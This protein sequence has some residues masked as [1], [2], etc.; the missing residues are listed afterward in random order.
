M[1]SR[2]FLLLALFLLQACANQLLVDEARWKSALPDAPVAVQE[3]KKAGVVDGGIAFAM[4][5]PQ[6]LEAVDAQAVGADTAHGVRRW[7]VQPFSLAGNI[8]WCLADGVSLLASGQ[9]G[10]NSQKSWGQFSTGLGLHAQAGIW[11][12]QFDGLLGGSMVSGEARWRVKVDDPAERDTAFLTDPDSADITGFRPWIALG[13]HGSTRSMSSDINLWAGVRYAVFPA[14]WQQDSRWDALH[15]EAP[16]VLQMGGGI[17]RRLGL[18]NRVVVGV[19]E[20]AAMFEPFRKVDWST[21]WIVQVERTLR[22]GPLYN[23]ERGDP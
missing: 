2:S 20:S 13:A 18:R 9:Y 14:F 15:I 7:D 16:H 6:K 4:Q 12:W 19:R 5:H 21:Q 23:P 10:F 3:R 22:V 8:D 17:W 1:R 11:A